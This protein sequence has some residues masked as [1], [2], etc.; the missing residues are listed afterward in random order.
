MHEHESKQARFRDEWTT[1]KARERAERAQQLEPDETD[2]AAQGP[3]CW[4]EVDAWLDTRAQPDLS[5]LSECGAEANAPPSSTPQREE[6]QG[7]QAE[8]DRPNRGSAAAHEPTPRH[9]LSR[10]GST[11]TL[12]RIPSSRGIATLA[13]MQT[14]DD[15]SSHQGHSAAGERL[16][17]LMSSVSVSMPELHH[18]RSGQRSGSECGVAVRVGR[19]GPRQAQIAQRKVQEKLEQA[20]ALDQLAE[21]LGQHA[22][23]AREFGVFTSL[24]STASASSVLLRGGG[25]SRRNTSSLPQPKPQRSRQGVHTHDM[26]N[27]DHKLALESIGA[28]WADQ[29]VS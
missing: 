29:K 1:R 20:Q 14:D 19:R 9:K 25:T 5:A 17:S 28:S 26:A 10:K 15:G 24:G 22:E 12:P 3:T 13:S 4:A 23:R 16:P 18:Q 21:K 2:E 11:G 27:I 6:E 7:Q 8:G